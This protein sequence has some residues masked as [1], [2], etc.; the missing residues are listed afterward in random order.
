MKND[1]DAQ[2]QASF[3]TWTKNSTFSYQLCHKWVVDRPLCIYALLHPVTEGAS[4]VKLDI[5]RDYVGEN[6]W[7]FVPIQGLIPCGDIPDVYRNLASKFAEAMRLYSSVVP[8]ALLSD[9]KKDLN[10]QTSLVE[11]KLD[12][13]Q[14]GGTEAEQVLQSIYRGN[15]KLLQK[16]AEME[17]IYG[18]PVNKEIQRNDFCFQHVKRPL[19]D[20]GFITKSTIEQCNICLFGKS[21]IDLYFYKDKGTTVNSAIIKALDEDQHA[22]D[23]EELKND[24]TNHEGIICGVTEFK[25]EDVKV[26]LA[27]MFADLVRV[28]SLLVYNSL[29]RGRL[30][31]KVVVYGLLANYNTG[32]A[33]ITKYYVDFT[34]NTSV[35][36][37]GD[38]TDA[39]KGFVGI[40]RAMN[41]ESC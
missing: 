2:M 15:L 5:F 4:R 10:F 18:K 21:L 28:G 27:Q 29:I 17:C 38:E 35:I 30:V 24:I 25:S 19:N 40:V 3:K 16:M 34:K 26:H 41:L 13:G 22:S 1:L 37:V 39:I 11:S 31:D 9:I 23:H 6:G 32:Y 8:L 36:Y 14:V 7:Q 12:V 20:L 33:Y